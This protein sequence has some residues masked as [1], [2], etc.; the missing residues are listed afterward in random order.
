MFDGGRRSKLFSAAAATAAL[1]SERFGKKLCYGR[2]DYHHPPLRCTTI[3]IDHDNFYWYHNRTIVLWYGH[4][5][6]PPG[7]MIIGLQNPPV[8][9]T[10]AVEK[11]EVVVVADHHYEEKKI[12]GEGPTTLLIMM[13]MMI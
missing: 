13:T 3:I 10:V 4:D 1:R 7:R 8:G 11:E 6:D 5:T 12:L 2:S 9:K